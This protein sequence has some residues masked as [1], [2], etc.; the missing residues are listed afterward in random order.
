MRT[1][2]R[3]PENAFAQPFEPAACFVDVLDFVAQV[4][5][6]ACRVL[7][8][9]TM[10]GRVFAKR[11]DQFDLRSESPILA[12]CVDETD[13]YTLLLHLERIAYS[14][15]T[16]DITIIGDRFLNRWRCD[17]NVVETAKF[18]ENT[19]PCVGQNIS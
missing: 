3:R 15:R 10:D 14:S 13:L 8:E 12:R 4:M 9:K 7:R 11:L 2:A 19:I 6:P 5:L 17:A 16:H 1:Y 18:H